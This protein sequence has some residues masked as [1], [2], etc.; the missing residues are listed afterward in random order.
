M[1][2]TLKAG[3]GARTGRRVRRLWGASLLLGAALSA[4]PGPGASKPTLV[5]HDLAG[6]PVEGQG[7]SDTKAP[8]D[9]L[10]ARAES[11]VRAPVWNFG[12]DS[13]GL[14]IR[15]VTDAGALRA[16]WR[17]RKPNRLAMPHMAASGVSGLDLYVRDGDSWHWLGVGAPD[18]KDLNERP[19]V[20]GMEKGRREYLLYLPLYNGVDSVEI[21]LPPDAS[22][23]PAPDRYKGRKPVVFYGSSRLQGACAS[24]PGMAYPSLIGRMLDW[25]VIN[26]GFSGNAKTEPEMAA[27]LAE[28]DPAVYVL[29]SLPNLTVAQTG[30]RM[31]PFIRTLRARHPAI[32]I[33]LV[34]L[35]D[36]ADAKYVA[37]RRDKANGSNALL[38]AL[39]QRLRAEG[40]RHLH[41]VSAAPVV[42][43]GS[44]GTVDGAHPTDLGFVRLAEAVGPV[45]RAALSAGDAPALPSAAS[46][47]PHP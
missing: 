26:L 47:L 3:R 21:G 35:V 45:V 40:D 33:V 10:P 29:D 43:L 9:R 12:Q 2:V 38:R 32:P 7:W 31:E 18:K 37:A 39:Y 41:Y 13:A 27:L 20:R 4:A 42:A 11:L 25:P 44:E 15:F 24:R 36:Y 46:S 14:R 30:E 17:L 16:R 22:F 19:L 8:Y 28:L 5:W 6:L 23:E 34:E 1:H